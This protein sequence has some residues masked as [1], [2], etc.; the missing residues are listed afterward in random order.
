[1]NKNARDLR[2]GD[3]LAGKADVP[4]GF[5][6]VQHRLDAPAG[7]WPALGEVV[8]MRR[9]ES[10]EFAQMLGVPEPFQRHAEI[11]M[12]QCAQALRQG[13]VTGFRRDG[14]AFD[15]GL[16]AVQHHRE[17]RHLAAEMQIERGLGDAR[18]ARDV[19][20]RRAAIAVP[21]EQDARGIDNLV[22]PQDG[23]GA[24]RCI[25]DDVIYKD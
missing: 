9:N 10:L 14:T 20:H 17:D 11:G 1:M 4:C 24:G 23:G 15:F 12:Q 5:R 13:G 7:T 22:E 3:A 16:A 21:H 18:F 8:G 19:V 2:G 25:H 6:P